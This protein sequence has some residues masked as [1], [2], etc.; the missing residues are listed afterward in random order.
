[1]AALRGRGL[2]RARVRTSARAVKFISYDA[3]A[4]RGDLVAE[5]VKAAK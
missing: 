2:I 1:M 3:I 4:M 5:I